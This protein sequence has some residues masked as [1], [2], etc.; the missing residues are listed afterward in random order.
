MNGFSIMAHK[1]YRNFWK[2]I[3]ILWLVDWWA[4]VPFREKLQWDSQ[5]WK[6]DCPAFVKST[7]WQFK[8]K[9]FSTLGLWVTI[10]KNTFLPTEIISWNQ[11]LHHVYKLY[12]SVSSN[13]PVALHWWVLQWISSVLFPGH[14]FP[15][16]CGLG[17]L[18]SLDLVL[19]P[20]SH[21]LVHTDQLVQ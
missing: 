9:L 12:E 2:G 8:A 18:Q 20:L 7:S 17:L 10:R 16:G 21:D 1:Y 11:I 3:L 19:T 4:I 5:T 15:S 13:K 14:G 6:K